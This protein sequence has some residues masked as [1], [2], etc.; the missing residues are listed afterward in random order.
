MSARIA[1]LLA[2]TFLLAACGRAGPMLRPEAGVTVMQEANKPAE[3]AAE[4]PFV[5]DPLL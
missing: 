1:T 3:K 2:L 5:L 4:K